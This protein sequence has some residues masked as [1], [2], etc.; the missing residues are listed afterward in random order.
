M[1]APEF[2]S[3]A[4]GTLKRSDAA[5]D[6]ETGS[7]ASPVAKRRSLHGIASFSSMAH[8]NVFDQATPAA[9]NFDIH[10]DVAQN[11]YA[12]AGST[13]RRETQPSPTPTPS[14]AR[15]SSS[16]RKST[17]QQRHGDKGSWGRRTGAQQLAQMGAEIP[18]PSRNRPSL[19]SGSMQNPPMTHSTNP[20]PLSR[21][22]K[23]SV[24]GSCFVED[25]PIRFEPAPN[26]APTRRLDRFKFSL[27]SSTSSIFS[28]S[29][30]PAP[31]AAQ[32]TQTPVV[33]PPAARSSMFMSSGLVSKVNRDPEEDKRMAVPDTPCK[34]SSSASFA[35][36]PPASAVRFRRGP[37]TPIPF[38][39]PHADRQSTP[40]SGT[41]KGLGLF[42]RL[43]G[44]PHRR[45]SVLNLDEENK[46]AAS[47]R[48]GASTP[49]GFPPTPTK[50]FLTPAVADGGLDRNLIDSPSANRRAP[51]I[52]AVKPA[53]SREPSSSP[54]RPRGSPKT[55]L[56]GMLHL[57]PSRFS[58]S[59]NGN[60][61]AE[62]YSPVPVTPSTS[63][64]DRRIVTP[65]HV[66]K[67]SRIDIDGHLVE[68]FH[69]VEE[70]GRGE[71]SVVYRVAEPKRVDPPVT[72]AP[73]SAFAVKKTRHIFAGP[74][75]R[76][77]KMKE[78]E[79]LKSLVHAKHVLRFVDSWEMQGHLYIQTEY[80]DEGTLQGF[81]NDVGH[82]GRMDDFRL[83]KILYDMLLGLQEVHNADFM[84]L[85]MKPANI[86]ITHEGVL[87][88][89]DFGLAAKWP[90][91][92]YIDA[93]G[94]REY[95]GPEILTGQYGKPSDLFA[96]GLMTLEMA[97][98]VQL[99]DNGMSWQA[100]R[101]G[102]YN[103]LPVQTPFELIGMRGDEP[104]PRSTMTIEDSI[105]G[106]VT[107]I[108][109]LR[110]DFG[111]AR[112][113]PLAEPPA[114]MAHSSHSL[115]LDSLMRQLTHPDPDQRPTVNEVLEFESF[116][117][118]ASRR[119]CA[120]TVFEGLFGP[121]EGPTQ[122]AQGDV[123]TVMMDA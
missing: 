55:P 116:R 2:S 71:F 95:I 61:S 91:T 110:P 93:E 121:R 28:K 73:G 65:I 76:D 8:D 56:D 111:V 89:G 120:A 37:A 90:V 63:Q 19:F 94:D 6:L 25:S 39:S 115:S 40:F 122:H 101:S 9:L 44:R 78:V 3:P 16:L 67:Q 20:H 21:S 42:H 48:D 119:R 58:I 29:L 22:L 51:P 4:A 68:R 7:L 97:G 99:P 108:P 17:L 100:L 34:K 14:A 59:N 36:Y 87:K 5:M 98:N 85:D 72:P 75:D 114:F 92:D 10:D 1:A 41:S 31:Q 24:S 43:G 26:Q 112:H 46:S 27:G 33:P 69:S 123:D 118:V 117:W 80:C 103:D 62:R 35:T 23:P 52:S 12:L 49:E 18:S 106:K 54:I 32:L 104:I 38:G 109:V 60:G 70:I 11:N 82:R 77:R 66:N 13:I 45:A 50:S 83:W 105:A 79:I 15:R 96:V 107:T 74:R 30:P 64:G 53:F 81:L 86:F 102:Q 88:I 57:D 113:Q 84:H 47:S